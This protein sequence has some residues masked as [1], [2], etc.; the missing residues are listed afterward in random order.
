MA[1]RDEMAAAGQRF[2]LAP[3]D[4]HARSARAVDLT[5]VQ[6]AVTSPA[7]ADAVGR[8]LRHAQPFQQNVLA[9]LDR[10]R[11]PGAVGE[12]ESLQPDMG[13]FDHLDQRL[14][15]HRQ[16]NIIDRPVRR[17]EIEH[18]VFPVHIPFAG[19]IEFLEQI[20]DVIPALGRMPFG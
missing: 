16:N 8:D 12:P 5:P 13:R 6:P 4:R 14:L 9:P 7:D 20:E 10:N 15:L 3:A 11:A 1:V 19:R 2:P 17:I 18:A